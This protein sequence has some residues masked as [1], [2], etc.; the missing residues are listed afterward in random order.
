MSIDCAEGGKLVGT[1]DMLLTER[2]VFRRLFELDSETL[3]DTEED[4][5]M[6]KRIYSTDHPTAPQEVSA[7]VL[8]SKLGGC[9][10][11]REQQLIQ[12]A[13]PRI[14]NLVFGGD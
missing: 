11:P 6:L 14:W 1:D 4:L 10:F 2:Q 12:K 9:T 8:A 3:I 7:Q 5:D 13:Y